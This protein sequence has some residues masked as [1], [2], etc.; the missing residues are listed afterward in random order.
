MLANDLVIIDGVG[1]N[2]GANGQWVVQSV[3]SNTITL[4]DSVGNA[5]YTSGGRAIRGN[6]GLKL[7]TDDTALPYP[8]RM[9]FGG[10]GTPYRARDVFADDN[11]YFVLESVI[12]TAK[13][14]NT[15]GIAG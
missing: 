9:T 1:G 4:K 7:M 10:D 8:E 15:F 13:A 12:L 5:A 3:S 2:T 14:A 11:E 6:F